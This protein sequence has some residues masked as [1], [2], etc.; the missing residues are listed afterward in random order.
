MAGRSGR[1]Y[2]A[3]HWVNRPSGGGK[4]AKTSG[5]GVLVA[6]LLVLGAWLGVFS[7]GEDAEGSVR[8]PS[9]TSSTPDR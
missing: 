8:Q 3:G 7:S 6:G 5:T 9:P 2:R 4:A 1:Y